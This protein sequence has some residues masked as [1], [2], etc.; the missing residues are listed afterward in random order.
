[1]VPHADA[2]SEAIDPR[3]AP[4]AAAFAGRRDVGLGRMFSSS[5]VLNAGGKIFAMLTR[6]QLVVKLPRDR[7]LALIEQG[8]GERFDPGHGRLMK[9]WVGVRE[10]AAPRPGYW[11]EYWI[12]LAE[13]AYRFVT[14]VSARPRGAIRAVPTLRGGKDL[15]PKRARPR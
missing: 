13:E 12:A 10:G 14:S 8:V 4:V 11:Q 6:D 5:S 2:Q 7:V 1:M 9:E 15:A 3:F